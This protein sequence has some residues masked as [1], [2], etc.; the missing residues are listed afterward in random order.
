VITLL[1]TLACWLGQPER[2]SIHHTKT[3]HIEMDSTNAAQAV[4]IILIGKRYL[5]DP[6]YS[7][8]DPG[9]N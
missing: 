3:I 8:L 4:G 2:A 1:V 7:R 6:P 9:L 5:G